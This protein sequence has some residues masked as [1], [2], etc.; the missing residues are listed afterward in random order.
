[1]KSTAMLITFIVSLTGSAAA[2][3]P[4][5]AANNGVSA[6]YPDKLFITGFGIGEGESVADRTGMAEQN[7]RTDLSA[8]FIVR[9]QSELVSHDVESQGSTTAISGIRP[10]RRPSSTWSAWTS[11]AMTTPGKSSAIPWR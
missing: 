4:D 3:Q 11:S 2:Q 10:A 5:W 6:S 9:I 8:K 7:A 1:M